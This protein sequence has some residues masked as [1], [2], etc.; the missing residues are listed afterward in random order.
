MRC[1]EVDTW[2]KGGGIKNQTRH[3]GK[4]TTFGARRGWKNKYLE[5][6]E[7]KER[8]ERSL[9]KF[10]GLKDPSGRD[11]KNGR[12]EPC[13]ENKRGRLP[14]KKARGMQGQKIPR[15]GRGAKRYEG[16]SKEQAT[17]R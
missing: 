5:G 6:A 8:S 2:S 15:S 7:G 13:S 10:A 4:R 12:D 11:R 9:K 14:K 1:P 17:R 3:E 16:A